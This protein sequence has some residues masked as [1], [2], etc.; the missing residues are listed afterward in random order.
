MLRFKTTNL[1]F[2]GAFVLL[3]LASFFF[4]VSLSVF[5]LLFVLWIIITAFGSFQIQWNYHVK[6]LH[7]NIAISKNEVAITFDDGP[8]PE[9]TLRVLSLLKQYNAKATFF[10]VGKNIASHPEIFK[11]ILAEG[12]TVGNHTYS[13]SNGFGFFSTQKVIEELQQTNAI[14]KKVAN[15][16]LKLYRPAFG[17]TNPNIKKALQVT[18]LQ[19]IGWNKRSFDTTKLSEEKIVKR[20]TKD[21]KKGDIILLHDSSEKT[22]KV[23]EQLLLFLQTKQMQS[24]PVDQLLAIEAYA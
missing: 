16:E 10:C 24:V 2:V 21:L 4:T 12:H 1:I 14:A 18:K 19:S 3:L 7:S 8:N 22:S 11:Q 9:Y 13:H 23:L 15:L 5:L 6:S 20:V 17:V